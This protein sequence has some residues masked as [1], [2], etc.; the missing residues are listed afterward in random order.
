MR[1]TKWLYH[2]DTD[3]PEYNPTIK[4][5]LIVLL[6]NAVMIPLAILLQ[7]PSV[8]TTLLQ[9]ATVFIAGASIFALFSIAL[10]LICTSATRDEMRVRQMADTIAPVEYPQESIVA[11]LVENPGSDVF[12]LAKGKAMK[13]MVNT[14]L[15]RKTGEVIHAEYCIDEKVYQSKEPFEKALRILSGN[16]AGNTLHL[17]QID[18]NDPTMGIPRYKRILTVKRVK[19]TDYLD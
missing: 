5:F 8:W 10:Q 14:E 13:I 19:H 12:I 11:F 18:G 17:L 7:I 4:K 15:D 6:V 16:P 2:V 1:W 3:L 9:V